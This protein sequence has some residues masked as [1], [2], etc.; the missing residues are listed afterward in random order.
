M[1]KIII[2][3]QV[4]GLSDLDTLVIVSKVVELGRVSNNNKQYCYAAEVLFDDKKFMVYTHLN[5]RSDRF[6]I[7]NSPSTDLKALN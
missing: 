4:S 3:N 6:V 2:D 7:T 1:N 5:K